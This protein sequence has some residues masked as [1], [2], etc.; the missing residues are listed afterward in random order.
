M[1]ENELKNKIK[2]LS[3]EDWIEVAIDFKDLDKSFANG[4]YEVTKEGLREEADYCEYRVKRYLDEQQELGN[5]KW[6]KS[7][8]VAN[9][10]LAKVKV[11]I[12]EEIDNFSEIKVIEESKEIT[13]DEKEKYHITATDPLSMSD[14]IGTWEHI[15][16]TGA[17]DVWAMGNYGQG[18]TVCVADT[19]VAIDHEELEGAMG[20]E[21][22]YHEGYW[23]EIDSGGNVVENSEPRDINHYH[24]THVA[25]TVLGRNVNYRIGMAPQATLAAVSLIPGGGGSFQQVLGGL[26]W[27][28]DN[29]DH[30]DVVQ[31]SWGASGVNHSVGDAIKT[32]YELGVVVSN[33][34][35][36]DGEGNTGTPG[37]TPWGIGVGA[38]NSSGDVAN[39]SGGDEV[40]DYDYDYDY[41][42]YE[43]IKPDIVAPGVNVYSSM[44]D[45]SYS[46]LSGTSMSGPHVAGACALLLRHNYQLSPREVMERLYRNTGEH[47]HLDL[48]NEP[49]DEEVDKDIR[50]GWGRLN[51]YETVMDV[52][53]EEKPPIEPPIPVEDMIINISNIEGYH[54]NYFDLISEIQSFMGHRY[55]EEFDADWL[56]GDLRVLVT[57]SHTLQIPEQI[58]IS[59]GPENLGDSISLPVS[60]CEEKEFYDNLWIT[61]RGQDYEIEIAQATEDRMDWKNIQPIVWS[62]TGSSHPAIIFNR[63]GQYIL[64]FQLIPAGA[65]DTEIWVLEPP[66]TG[67]GLRR[68]GYGYNPRFL[69]TFEGN[70]YLF[71]ETLDR[72][73]IVYLEHDFSGNPT[74]LLEDEPEEGVRLRYPVLYEDDSIRSVPTPAVFYEDE[75]EGLKYYAEHPRK[76]YCPSDN[77]GDIFVEFNNMD[78]EDL[79]VGIE[80]FVYDYDGNLLPNAHVTI[81]G[82]ID[83]PTVSRVTGSDGGTGEIRIRPYATDYNVIIN[84]HVL[85]E[86][87]YFWLLSDQLEEGAVFHFQYIE[88]PILEEIITLK[89][90][91]NWL[92]EDVR[93]D[94]TFNVFDQ[95]G[96]IVPDAE[97]T[98]LGQI[99][100]ET[101][102]G[103]TDVNGQVTL[104]EINAYP[105]EYR[106]EVYHSELGLENK[107]GFLIYDEIVD[108][109]L[110]RTMD[111]ELHYFDPFEEEIT[112]TISFDFLWEGTTH[113]VL[114]RILSPEGQPIPDT[115][116]T[117]YGQGTQDT[118]SGVTDSNGEIQFTLNAYS[119]PYDMKVEHETY[120]TYHTEVFVYGMEGLFLIKTFNF[121]REEV[122]S[123]NPSL[124]SMLWVEII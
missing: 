64:A 111:V 75:V 80:I 9:T 117:V 103:V 45:G 74:P 105:S 73:Q 102:D 83:Q 113:D 87:D 106:V 7:F 10:I 23:A 81:V 42:N 123:L 58:D 4:D 16:R 88:H 20:G 116:I 52:P 32:L 62:P 37:N 19:G 108:P 22:P 78:W 86:A 46:G 76:A 1:I 70:I 94:V 11:F 104:Y 50:W 55:R 24:G 14:D 110:E 97:L 59:G 115:N 39:F 72:K 122:I 43:H 51:I 107:W 48:E 100:Q 5:V 69:E 25:G 121:P 31:N 96:N 89:P 17:P 85:G 53:E 6:H 54:F 77:L 21:P 2:D 8:W 30:I 91:L 34:I 65:V 119:T 41:D 93:Y 95:E 18:I 38:T 26:Q 118:V 82:Q 67:E 28:A 92:W 15:E 63:R 3:D 29:S 90:E 120:G 61:Y 112:P 98:L 36:N 101:L 27:I 33:S 57:R 44:D 114:F 40:D 49:S 66:Y 124:D 12:V 84:H 35:G 71:Y 60:P 56:R 79:R 109:E 99:D 68:V 47:H 13:I